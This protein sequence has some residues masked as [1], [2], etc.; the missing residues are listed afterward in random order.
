MMTHFSEMNM[1]GDDD[2]KYD[3]EQ[4][5]YDSDYDSEYD[6]D[7]CSKQKRK[8]LGPIQLAPKKCK[9][10]RCNWNGEDTECE[11]K[12][13]TLNQMQAHYD[14]QLKL[15]C[16]ELRAETSASIAKMQAEH[17]AVLKALDDQSLLVLSQHIAFMAT[18]PKES[19]AGRE[20]REAEKKKAH[21]EKMSRQI[22]KGGGFKKRIVK[23]TDPEVIKAR[24]ASR[25]K[26]SRDLKKESE[27]ERA[28]TFASRVECPSDQVKQVV[29]PVV[30]SVVEPVVEPVV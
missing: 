30:E 14:E 12:W 23:D 10:I 26:D 16:S 22:R 28:K 25:R 15:K 19:K 29:E 8:V 21:Q 1:E 27:V 5:E 6:S 9:C 7:E 11:Q 20:R 18:L 4:Q 3:Y 17:K 13:I 24:R 2:Y